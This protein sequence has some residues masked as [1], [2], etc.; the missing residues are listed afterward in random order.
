MNAI[1]K[2]VYN[3]NDQP[4]VSISFDFETSA[5]TAIPIYRTK[6]K[7]RFYKISNSFNLTNKDLSAGLGRGYGNRIGAET[8]LQLFDGFGIKATWFCTGHVLLKENKNGKMFRINQEL[9][10]ATAEAGFT[11]A[12]TWR[13]KKNSFYHEPFSDYKT[14]PFYYFG[15]LAKEI[16][17]QG[18]DIQCHSFSHPYISMETPTN[19]KTDLEDWQQLAEKEG[20]GKSNIFAFPFLGD[21]HFTER[22]SRLKTIPTFR[23]AGLDYDSSYLDENVLNIFKNTG[24]ELFTRCGSLQDTE[25]ISGFIPYRNS[26]IYC[27]RDFGLFSFSNRISFKKFLEEVIRNNANIDLWLHPNDIME[28]EKFELFKSFIDELVQFRDDGKIWLCTISEQWER[29]KKNKSEF[30]T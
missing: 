11:S 22:I 14:H 8:I 28:N 1:L 19:I 17:Y 6:L 23:K 29:F 15:D 26:E 24:F 27:M 25:S 13:E 21:Y 18:H 2:K 20:F 9:P 7:Y 16:E 10:Y 4:S 5:Q 12:T 30:I 3:Q